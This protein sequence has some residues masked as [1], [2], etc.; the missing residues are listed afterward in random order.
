MS[1]EEG[2]LVSYDEFREIARYAL[3]RLDGSWFRIAAAHHGME[4]ATA[5]DVEVSRDYH[6]RLGRMIK[7]KLDLE[8]R[9]IESIQEDLPRIGAIINDLNG[10]EGEIEFPSDDTIFGR[11][12][13]CKF[14]DNI[15]KAGFDQ[16]AQSGL[17]CSNVHVASYEGI[18][19]G[20]YPDQTFEVT[21]TK[22]IPDGD[23]CCEV[24][25]KIIPGTDA[26]E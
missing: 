19:K 7:K 5:M 11:I 13:N 18:L 16:F 1:S 22:R 3:T 15:K 20:L 6:E 17:M 2:N 21:H 4:E 25:I 8:G 14:W 24:T 23:P 9:G 26:P 12:T 10:N